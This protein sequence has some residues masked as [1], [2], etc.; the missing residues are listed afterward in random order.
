MSRT[1]RIAT[2]KSKMAMTQTQRA[3]RLLQD[4]Y[5]EARFEIIPMT[6]DGC[7]EKYKG[8][9]SLIGGKGAFVKALELAMLA[10]DADMAM[11]SMKDVPTDGDIPEGLTIPYISEREDVRDAAVCRPGES[12]AALK[13]GA[14]IGTS[15]VRR[16]AQLRRTM[17]HLEIVPLRGNADTRVGKVDSGEV[18]AAILAYAGLRRIGLQERVTDVFEP[19]LL[20]PAVGQGSVGLECRSED[21]EV[22]EMLQRINHQDSFKQLTAE[23]AMLMALGGSCHT[24]IGGLCTLESETL[25]TLTGMVASL[26]GLT[27]VRATKS[28]PAED[29]EKLGQDVAQDLLSQGAGDVLAACEQAA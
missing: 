22:V 7:Y 26:D 14:K 3:M 16:A 21:Q 15:S 1:F 9:L 18:D 10:K 5:K 2:R 6:S 17:P 4:A 19:D 28:G 20:L 24:P 29:P 11:H 27:M 8:D 23:R 25:L 13:P 12:L